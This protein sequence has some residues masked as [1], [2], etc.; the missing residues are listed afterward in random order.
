M[1]K[2]KEKMMSL[3]E[4]MTGQR[5]SAPPTFPVSFA[6]R[7]ERPRIVCSHCGCEEHPIESYWKFHPGNGSANWD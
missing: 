5:T 6:P 4:K 7:V 1:R 3:F 2:Q